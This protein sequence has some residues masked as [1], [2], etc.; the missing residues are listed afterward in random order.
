MAYINVDISVFGMRGG[1]AVGEKR[2]TNGLQPL[3][4]LGSSHSQHHPEGTGDAPGPERHLLCSQTGGRRRGWRGWGGLD[5][6]WP[7][8]ARNIV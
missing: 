6:G 3:V 7:C 2:E 5:G 1:W 8:G 4:F